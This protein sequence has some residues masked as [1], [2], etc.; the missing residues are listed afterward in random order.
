MAVG[1]ATWNVLTLMAL[2]EV[3]STMQLIP[4]EGAIA[5]TL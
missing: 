3:L 5:T 2:I 4:E 1:A